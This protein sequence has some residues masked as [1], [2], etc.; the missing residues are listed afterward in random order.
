MD[1]PIDSTVELLVRLQIVTLVG[2]T[3][4]ADIKSDIPPRPMQYGVRLVPSPILVF[5]ESAMMALKGRDWDNGSAW[6]R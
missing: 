6:Y 2:R 4:D 3:T 1:F 5:E